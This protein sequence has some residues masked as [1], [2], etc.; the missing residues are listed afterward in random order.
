MR[1]RIPSKFV[2]T[3][4][5]QNFLHMIVQEFSFVQVYFLKLLDHFLTR[6]TLYSMSLFIFY[7][8][9]FLYFFYFLPINCSKQHLEKRKIIEKIFNN[10]IS[11]IS[12]YLS[13]I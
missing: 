10:F 2:R 7:I 4:T 3:R 8:V 13:N 1:D 11:F 9:S 5:I 12:C 6:Y